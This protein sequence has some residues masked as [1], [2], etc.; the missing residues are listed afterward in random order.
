MKNPF[1]GLIKIYKDLP[2]KRKMLYISYFQILIPVIIIGFVSYIISE[3]LIQTKSIN[4]SLDLMRTMEL[5]LTDCVNNLTSISQDLLYDN[6][7]YDRLKGKDRYNYNITSLDEFE[8]KNTIDN[9]LN[10]YTFSRSEIQA[11]YFE[12]YDRKDKFYRDNHSVKKDIKALVK[13][14]LMSAVAR[15]G[16]GKAMWYFTMNNGKADNLFLLRTIYD[17]DNFKEIGLMV[18]LVNKE[19]F[20]S[21]YKG[22]VNDEMQ[23]VVIISPDNKII[24]SRS[25]DTSNLL[26][27]SRLRETNKR[28]GWMIDQNKKTLFTYVSMDDP[29]WR[30]MSYIPLKLLYKDIYDFRTLI[31]MLCIL[32]AFLL[33]LINM[34]ISKDFVTPIKR[35]ENAMKQIQKGS[36]KDIEVDRNDE[37]GF[38]TRTF[39]EMSKEISHLITWIYRE[40][41]TRKEAQLKA[42]QSQINPHFLFNTLESINWMAQLQNVPEISDMVTALSSLMEANIGRDDKLIPLRDEFKYIDHYIAILK[43]RFEDRIQLK[44]YVD[45]DDILE[46]EIPKLLIQPIIEN[47]VYHGICD[48]NKKGVINLNSYIEYGEL[49]IEVVDN[50]IGMDKESVKALNETL[51]M[52]NDTYFRT[53]ANEERKSIGLENVNRRIKLFYGEKY[54]LRITSEK[55]EFTK[56]RVTIPLKDNSE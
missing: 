34:K 32:T 26:N 40:Q 36:H 52:D 11:I 7:I 10:K 3:N 28:G 9:T 48:I 1:R 24:L 2:I 55:D 6:N 12:T 27:K 30:I 47:A 19:L 37:L 49:I 5:R 50:G 41:I 25:P 43:N 45:N 54:G 21:V 53:R 42:L 4:Y 20:E 56:V 15:K 18:F 17:R 22:L 13:Y 16:H 33:T 35:L 23:N 39:N 14:D 51:A 29:N 31:I 46:L 44:V 8:K 38:I